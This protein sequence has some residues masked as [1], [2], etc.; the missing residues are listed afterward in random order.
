MNT[1]KAGEFILKKIRIPSTELSVSSIGLGTASA[2][3]EWKD[4]AAD[5]VFDE[6][7]ALG[8]NLIDTA[9]V[10][11]DWVKPE[12]ARSERVI[13]EWLSRRGKRSEVVLMT[14]GG[15]PDITVDLP[16][17][18]KS[19]MAKA[20]MEADLDSSLQK[21]QTD[22]IDIY[23]YHRDDLKQPVEA[24]VDLMEGFVKQGK[25]RYYA[26]SNWNTARMKTADEYC[27]QK[28]YHGFVANQALLNIGLRHM[29]PMGDDTMVSFDKGMAEY[30]KANPGNLAMP[31]MGA[32]GGFFHLYASG[33]AE[34]VAS[35]P[36]YTE[37]NLQVAQRVLELAKK[38]NASI[39]QV[40]LGFFRVLDFPCCPLYGPQNLEQLA[41]ALKTDSIPFQKED[42]KNMMV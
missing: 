14:K 22:Y 11:S 6:F 12:T 36:Y 27:G 34:S 16:D 19:R 30:H 18:H 39:T 24:L 33:G 38:Y 4:L 17:M 7:L 3:L 1:S 9:H 2:G 23:F 37:G 28:G 10:Y 32:C 20:D 29:C 41:D 35:S 42:Y 13:G 40:L 15:H 8:G 26:C 31:Y 21:L 25:I 5:R